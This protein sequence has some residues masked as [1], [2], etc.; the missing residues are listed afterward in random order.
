VQCRSTLCS[1]FFKS[2][3]DAE[4][5]ATLKAC[6]HFF[7]FSAAHPDSSIRLASYQTTGAF[8]LK[9]NRYFPHQLQRTF[10]DISTQTA[11]DLKSSAIIPS[12]FAFI[13]NTVAIPYLEAFLETTPVYHHFA[14]SDP[15][16]SE[17]LTSIISNLGDLGL[18]WYRILL[19]SFLLSVP[20]SK[21]QFLR[22]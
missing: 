11:V 15:L 6:W 20:Q 3:A 5:A 22:N 1:S 13:S 16:F 14:T 17:H 21:D 19:H 9:L 18:D 4:I 10:S 8:L 12:V 2:S 7:L